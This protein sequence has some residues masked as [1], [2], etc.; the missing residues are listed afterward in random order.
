M[1]NNG[2]NGSQGQRRVAVVAGLR[3]PFLKSRGAFADLTALD[4]GKAVVSELMAR[5]NLDKKQVDMLVYGQVVPSVAAPNVAREVVL[6]TG[7]PQTVDA[8]SVSRACATAVQ[9]TTDA[10][11]QI[12]LGHAD[13]AITGGTECLSDVPISVSRKLSNALVSASKAR[14][15]PSKLKSFAE[16]SA[17]DLLPV[18]PSIKEQSTGL[19]MGESAEKMAKE[20]GITREEQDR[21]A[22]RSHDLAARA[23]AEGKY[24]DEV[25]TVLVPPKYTKHAR[26][27]DFIRK[28]VSLDKMAELRPAFDSRYGTITAANSSGLT[29]GASALLLMSEEKAQELGYQPLGFIRSYAYAAIDPKWQML[30]GPS[31]ATPIALDRAGLKLKDM[32]IVDIHEAFAA[33]VLCNLKAMASRKFAEEHLGRSE[34]VGEVDESKMNVNGGSIAL[35]HPFGATGGRMLLNTLNELKRRNQQFGLVTLCAAGGL[36]AAVVLERNA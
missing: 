14:D 27:D 23:W 32:D 31:F 24:K 2:R 6:G 34:P 30:M 22:K 7:L 1:K 16:L 20:H 11:D 33:V 15:I 21:Y 17:K 25:M 13:V 35:G 5:T 26:E 18:P 36:G 9:A 3:T 4:L 28:D 12:A 10:A 8:W 29:D 19:T